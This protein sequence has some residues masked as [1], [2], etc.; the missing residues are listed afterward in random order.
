MQFVR[1]KATYINGVYH[2][3][4]VVSAPIPGTRNIRLTSY[5]RPIHNHNEGW[6]KLNARQG[7]TE[8]VDVLLDCDLTILYEDNVYNK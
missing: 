6:S 7:T 3:L 1:S 4:L 5:V 8:P 2:T